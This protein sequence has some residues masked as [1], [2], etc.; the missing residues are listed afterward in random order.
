MLPIIDRV[1]SPQ[2]WPVADAL[3]RMLAANKQV[4]CGLAEDWGHWNARSWWERMVGSFG[5]PLE[6]RSQRTMNQSQKIRSTTI[7]TV[8][9]DGRVAIGGDGQVSIGAT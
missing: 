5:R 1:C 4:K 8:R 6:L 9:R 2:F 7:L 3:A